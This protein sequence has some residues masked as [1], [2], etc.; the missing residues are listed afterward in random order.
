MMEMFQKNH[1]QYST[2]YFTI[3]KKPIKC[4]RITG[5]LMMEIYNLI[6]RSS[7]QLIA[8]LPNFL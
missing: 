4:D 8:G 7:M 3:S 5:T 1:Q 2:M 6:D